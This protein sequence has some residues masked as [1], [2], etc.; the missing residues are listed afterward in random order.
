[1]KLSP[2]SFNE[3]SYYITPSE[4]IEFNYCQRFIY[5]MKCLGI[6]QYEEKRY[7]VQK[8][9]DVH[10]LRERQNKSYLRKKLGVIDKEIDV[11]LV[12]NLYKIRG[13]VDEILILEDNT[14]AP[15]D[16]KFAV[17]NDKIYD[18]YRTQ[19]IMYG[20][21][22]KE[23]YDVDVTRGYLIYCRSNNK[24]V[25][26]PITEKDERKLID[27]I[28]QFQDVMQ[29]Y[30]PKATRYKARCDDCCYRNICIK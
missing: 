22:I 28:K 21:M 19:I 1:M 3:N 12:S 16:Y 15:L 26:L 5:F 10:L 7:K 4:M 18:T 29:G 23:V 6:E 11:Q 24:I 13:K 17:Y 25:E 8:G 2:S 27:K 30:Y 9:K 20:L 14:M